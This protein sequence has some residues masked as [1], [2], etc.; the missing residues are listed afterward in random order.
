M[1]LR[2]AD[3]TEATVAK[4]TDAGRRELRELI[5]DLEIMAKT[6]NVRFVPDRNKMREW[7]AGRRALEQEGR[8][9]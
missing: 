9:S 8:E 3:S 4:V 6:I 2:L 5:A 1:A 7:L